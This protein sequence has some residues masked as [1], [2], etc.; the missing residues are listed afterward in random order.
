MITKY[1]LDKSTGRGIVERDVNDELK[2][3]NSWEIHYHTPPVGPT[4]DIP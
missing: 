4:H 2:K 3:K 1:V